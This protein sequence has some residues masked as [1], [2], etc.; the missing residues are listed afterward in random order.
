M[1]KL[2][3]HWG[4]LFVVNPL[5]TGGFLSQTQVMW[6][7]VVFFGVSLNKL[8]NKQSSYR[9]FET[10]WLMCQNTLKFA[11]L[12]MKSHDSLEE[13]PWSNNNAS[14]LCMCNLGHTNKRQGTGFISHSNN[15]FWSVSIDVNS[16]R[17]RYASLLQ[18]M[19]WRLLG[20]KPSSEPMQTHCWFELWKQV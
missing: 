1:G 15:F 10:P 3:Y 14:F 16:L 6:N 13:F 19:A 20:A 4:W 18:I 8:M 5:A 2:S 11:W 17:L 7:F 9:W 12:Y